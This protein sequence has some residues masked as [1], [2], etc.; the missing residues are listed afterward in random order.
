MMIKKYATAATLRTGASF[1]VLAL[2]AAWSSAAA[3][4]D[5]APV[6]PAGEQVA[7]ADDVAAQDEITVTGYRASLRSAIR[8]KRDATVQI[9]AINA[10]DIADFPDTNLAESLQ[11]LPGVSIDRDNG[12]GR[13]ITVRGLGGD[14]NRTRLNGLEALSTAGA[15]DAGTS[16]NRSRA[17]DY[18]TFASELFSSLKVQ[19]TPSAETDEGSLGATIDLQTGRPFDY[20]DTAFALSGEGSYQQNSRKWNPRIS[21]L[22]SKRFFGGSM[23]FLVSGAWSK[24]SNELDQYRRAPGQ[25]DFLYRNSDF[26]GNEN[27]QRAGF[28]APTGTSFGSVVTNPEAIAAMTGSDPAA[29]AK[30]YPGAPYNTA[31][32]FDD[33]LVRI[34]ALAAIEQQDVRNERLGLTASYQ[35]QISDRTLLSIDGAYSRFWNQSTYNQVSSV[36]LNRNNTNATYNTA[37]NSITP[38]AARALYPGLCTPAADSDLAPSQDCGQ[39]LYGTTPAFATA[40]NSA[41]V[42]APSILGNAAV[43][44]GGTTPANATIFS[45]NPFNLDPYDYYNNPGSV[46]YIPSANRLAF[47]GALIGRPAVELLDANVT[48]GLADY[49]VMRNVDFRSAADQS[50]YTT[51]FKQ[52]S[53]NLQ[54]A[55]SDVFKTE[56]TAGMSESTNATQGLLVEFNRMDSQ[57]SFVYDERGGGSMPKI[58]LG[59]D[60]AN[61][62][63]WEVVKGFSAIRHYQRFVKNTYKQAKIDFDW[64]ANDEF[65]LGFG[66]NLR[67]YTFDT[68]LYERNNDLL[69]PTLREAGVTTASVSRTINFGQG[70]NVPDG[71]LTSFIAPSIAA[72]DNLFDFTCNCVNKWGDWRLTNKRNGG[73]ENFGVEETD[74]GFYFQADWNSEIFGR[75]FRGNAGTRIAITDVTSTG[76]TTAGRPIVGTNRYTDYLPSVNVVYEPVDNLLVRLSASKVMARPLLGNLAPT[77]TAISIPN[78]GAT[79]GATL[80]VGNPKLKPFRSTNFDASVEWYFAPGGLLSFAAFRKEIDSFPQTIFFSA[81]LST[82]ADAESIAAIRAQ[83]T[84]AQ[85]LAYIDG[86]YDFQARQFADAPGGWLQGIEASFQMDFTFLPG[87]FKNFGAQLNYTHIDSELNY[88]LDPGSATAPRTIGKGPFI[89]V[90]PDAVNATLYYESKPFRARVSVAHRKG[91]STAYPIAAGSCSPGII[92]PVSAN[93]GTVAGNNAPGGYCTGPLINDF[94]FSKSTT[95]VDASMS[96]NF[97]DWV[98]LSLEGLNLTN[99]TS[100]RYAYEGQNAVTQ[101]ASSGRIFRAGVRFRF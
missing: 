27:P 54:H 61:P 43:V 40:Y 87:L 77:I 31:G 28:A 65:N 99:Q 66:A 29:Y 51:K 48:N 98:S 23:G 47:R 14:F 21:G 101:Y 100:D 16:P 41:G 73:R 46:G 15:N 79:A 75:P 36:G 44:P 59:F 25:A 76:S 24:S 37:T 19:K 11:R 50:T 91:Y 13:T 39:Q 57:G 49:L 42:L 12:E 30:L 8:E 78:T 63:N 56:I 90:S 69:N 55:F 82:F 70:L 2:A 92:P 58:D 89:G 81:P 3:A 9:D 7:S 20:K 80:T 93:P 4:Q 38:V 5:A 83:F 62:A 67:K 17:F 33:S 64:Q 96:F 26:L 60:A 71:T 86:N 74:T 35:W 68:S 85:Q 1:A 94:V 97:T 88:I 22:A 45:V 6:A 32:R 18:N 84:N 10:E 34:P 95:N 53:I 52:G 72:F